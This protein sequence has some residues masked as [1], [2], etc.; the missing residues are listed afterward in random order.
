MT[1][2][3]V[4]M[5][6]GRIHAPFSAVFAWMTLD[7]GV[8]RPDFRCV[9]LLTAFCLLVASTQASAKDS[10]S[11]RA[12]CRL[13]DRDFQLDFDSASGD[14]D[15]EDMSVSLLLPDRPAL[16]LPLKPGVFR[17]RSVVSNQASACQE[18]GA[19]LIRD[20]LHKAVPPRLLLWLSVKD[21][22]GWD[23]LSLVLI[24]LEAGKVLH[25]IERVAPIK[26]PDGR[27]GLMLQ[28]QPDHMLIRLQRHWLSNTGTDSPENSIEDWY[29]VEVRAARILGAWAR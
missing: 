22:P 10:I 15:A 16:S 27:Q 1:G 7:R 21:P 20:Q 24:D 8:R 2:A 19:Y 25:Q 23:Q 9:A 28:V 13:D 17:P 4:S 14:P 18:L 6:N 11:W 29:R 26:D 3:R 5:S 12:E